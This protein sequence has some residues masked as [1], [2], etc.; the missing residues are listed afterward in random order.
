MRHSK[1]GRKFN[2][3]NSHR[4]AMLNNLAV[5][6]LKWKQ[7][8]TT[9]AKAKDVRRIV[10]KLITLGKKNT[11]HHKRLAFKI[12]K[13]RSLVKE[14]FDKISTKY[15]SRLGGYTQI[16]KYGFRKGDCADMSIIKLIDE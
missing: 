8:K 9:S 15:E 1:S 4:M 16:I 2:R 11:L 3:S 7:V 14:L 6:I 12:I 13:N 10:E 5:S